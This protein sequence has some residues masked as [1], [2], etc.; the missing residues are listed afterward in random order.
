MRFHRTKFLPPE[1]QLLSSMSRKQ[2]SERVGKDDKHITNPG[3]KIACYRVSQGT[4]LISWVYCK[5]AYSMK[6]HGFVPSLSVFDEWRRD[7]LIDVDPKSQKQ[8]ARTGSPPK[9]LKQYSE[10]DYRLAR[11]Y[12]MQRAKNENPKII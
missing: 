5:T 1:K 3:S 11:S 12:D 4:V 2:R 8:S 10:L 7:C 9:F 6:R